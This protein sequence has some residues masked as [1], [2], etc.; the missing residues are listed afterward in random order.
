[1]A[2]IAVAVHAPSVPRTGAAGNG[3]P[4]VT[5]G[6]QGPLSNSALATSV[7]AASR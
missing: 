5:G 6:R 3:F 7:N 1:V 2:A 4:A